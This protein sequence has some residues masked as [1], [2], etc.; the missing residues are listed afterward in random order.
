MSPSEVK[1]QITKLTPQDFVAE[2]ILEATPVAF[3]SRTEYVQWKGHLATLLRVDAL[4]IVLVGSGAVGCSLNPEKNYSKFSLKSDID[5]AIVSPE[6]FE[7]GWRYMRENQAQFT[8]RDMKYALKQHKT[9][10]IFHGVIDTRD[11]LP[12]LPF[13]KHWLSARESMLE[14][15]PTDTRTL[16]FRLYKDSK[17]LREYHTRNVTNLKAALE[18]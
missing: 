11:I 3:S 18:K 16:N 1:A 9:H 7:E 8:T 17:G 4:D 6:L 13:G 2:H 12:A 5:V 15:P 10:F 14:F